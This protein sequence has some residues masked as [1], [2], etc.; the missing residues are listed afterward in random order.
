M[1]SNI[2]QANQLKGVFPA[3]FTP[4]KDDD[5][6]R[7]RNSIDYQ[8]TKQMIDDLIEI[9]VDGIVPMGTTGQSATVSPKQHIEFIC[10]VADYVKGRVPI[11]A[12]AGSNSTRESI[13]TIQRVQE[14]AGDFTFLCVTGYYNNPPQEGLVKHF[15]TI[16]DETHANLVIYNV[17]GRTQNYIESETL[18]TLAQHPNIIGLKQAVDFKGTGKMREDTIKVIKESQD[19]AVVS[20]EDDSLFEI[21]KLGGT[22]IIT[23][24]GNIPEASA[25]FIKI[26]QTFKEGNIELSQN[27]Q[28]ELNEIAN[29][30]FCLKNPIPLA[31]FFNS[32]L[33]QPLVSVRETKG[34]EQLHQTL[35]DFIDKKLGSLK[36]YF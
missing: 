27:Y 22:G 17:P 24:T 20:G 8:K 25:L 13:E 36:K 5:S 23:A 16:A 9:G 35:I 1:K 29:L 21:L 14:K 15:T 6:K 3:L 10:F 18:L 4:L 2:I 19:F 12:G 11:I 30:C 32:V 33:Y 26:C 34:G 31:T 7:L 28:L